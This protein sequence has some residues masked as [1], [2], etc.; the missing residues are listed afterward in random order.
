M[1]VS[2]IV[3]RCL[4]NHHTSMIRGSTNLL[5][6]MRVTTVSVKVLLV[7]VSVTRPGPVGAGGSSMGSGF[8]MVTVVTEFADAGWL[9]SAFA[10]LSGLEGSSGERFRKWAG[11]IAWNSSLVIGRGCTCASSPSRDE[12]GVARLWF[13][14]FVPL[15]LACG[16]AFCCC[17]VSAL[18]RRRGAG[19][20]ATGCCCCCCC[21][22]CWWWSMPFVFGA[23]G[24]SCF[25]V[26]SGSFTYY[27]KQSSSINTKCLCNI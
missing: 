17:V 1:Q 2:V 16:T 14:W 11:I 20:G 3:V 13:V 19:F 10:W 4:H 15:V 5:S 27:Q 21:C 18:F 9:L 7:M 12:V 25:V 24:N 8:L 6:V 22:C 26:G 23:S